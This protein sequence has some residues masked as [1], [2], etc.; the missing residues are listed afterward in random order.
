MSEVKKVGRPAT[1]QTPVRTVR[2]GTSWDEAKAIA[3][4]RGEKM[5]AIVEEALRRYIRRHH[6][7]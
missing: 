6:G 7:E 5:A 4:R 3:D 2:V 1:G